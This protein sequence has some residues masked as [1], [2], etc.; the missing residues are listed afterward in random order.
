MT[1]STEGDNSEP[2]SFPAIGRRWRIAISVLFIAGQGI[3]VVGTWMQQIATV[4]LV[5]RLSHS[6]ILLGLTDFAAQI[7]AALVLPLVGVLSDRWNRHRTV[8]AMQTL[9]MI[10]AFVLTALTA[11][12]IISV[13]QIILLGSILGIISAFDTTARQT[14]I[15]QMIDR[16]E[17]LPNAVAINSSV[18]NAARLIGPAIAGVVIGICGE[19]PCFLANALSYLAVLGSLLAM[20]IRP[21]RVVGADEGLVNGFRE[22]LR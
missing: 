2:A 19:W 21:F 3:S 12:D 7:P 18:F 22:G 5:Y 1:S 10:Q 16:Q 14:F 9:A 13:W 20:R 8:I 11:A 6:T 4:W 17:D 15:V